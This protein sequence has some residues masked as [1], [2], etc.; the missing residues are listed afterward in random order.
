MGNIHSTSTQNINNS[1][2]WTQTIAQHHHQS[3]VFGTPS[4]RSARRGSR[5]PWWAHWASA[6]RRSRGPIWV[7]SLNR[8]TWAVLIA[9]VDRLG[10]AKNSHF[11]ESLQ[12]LQT[13]QKNQRTIQRNFAEVNYWGPSGAKACKS[14]R[15][16]QELSNDIY[17]QKSASI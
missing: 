5:G 16:R 1:I 9:P 13:F 14:C 17:L 7:A 11:L 4:I 12:L 8:N 6:R 15:S 2:F 3:M 10:K